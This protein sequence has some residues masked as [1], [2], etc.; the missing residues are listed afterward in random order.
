MPG[1]PVSEMF[2]QKSRT[3]LLVVCPVRVVA[4]EHDWE[5]NQS[6]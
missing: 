4:D 5:I 6:R 1:E 3:F 2:R